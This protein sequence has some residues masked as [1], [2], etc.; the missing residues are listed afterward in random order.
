[1]D[2][3]LSIGDHQAGSRWSSY[4]PSLMLVLV[5]MLVCSGVW[6][7][8]QRPHQVAA[9]S[10]AAEA[11]VPSPARSA[12]PVAASQP[13]AA[14]VESTGSTINAAAKP[15][16]GGAPSEAVPALEPQ[17]PPVRTGTSGAD[18]LADPAQPDPRNPSAAP[19]AAG[20]QPVHVEI[21]ASEPAWV[22]ATSDGNTVFSATLQPNQ[23]RVVD[24]GQSVLLRLGNAGAV[25][26]TLNGKSIGP[27]GQIGQV[28]NLQ[29]TSGGFQIVAAPKSP[30]PF[31]PL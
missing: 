20:G 26:I 16:G 29:L 24:A 31:D 9:T 17:A 13:V 25:T 15:S 10:P 2:G 30:V 19:V 27:A 5:V 12:P 3:W 7:F 21:T 28:R 1:M 8:L 4:L 22:R 11:A 18:R 6:A 14:P 23:T